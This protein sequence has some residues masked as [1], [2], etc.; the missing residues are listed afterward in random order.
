MKFYAMKKYM[1][2]YPL[3]WLI[4][5]IIFVLSFC[6]IPK[7]PI[8]NVPFIDKWVHICMY[9]GLSGMIWIE[10]LKSHIIFNKKHILVGA[11]FLPLLMS[12]T[13]ELGQK[14]LTYGR[15]NGDWL[16]FTANSIGVFIASLIGYFILRHTIKTKKNQ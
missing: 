2:N 12:G 13:I 1:I 8:N 5:V 4:I 3:T 9:G 15:R 6:A 16:D 11:I 10:Y 14:F 7:T